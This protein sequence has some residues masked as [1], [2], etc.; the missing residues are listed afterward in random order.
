MASN[1][2]SATSNATSPKRELNMNPRG[3]RVLA[4]L[5]ANRGRPAK[6]SVGYYHRGVRSSLFNS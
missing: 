6:G 2:S 4:N 1:T 5:R 3:N